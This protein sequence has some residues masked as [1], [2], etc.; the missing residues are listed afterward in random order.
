MNYEEDETFLMELTNGLVHKAFIKRLAK[1]KLTRDEV[2]PR[3]IASRAIS[4]LVAAKR[5]LLKVNPEENAYGQ[6][7]GLKRTRRRP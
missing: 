4:E 7:K 3:M 1:L 2:E 5:L 6:S